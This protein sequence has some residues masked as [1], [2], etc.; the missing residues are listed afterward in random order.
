R[1]FVDQRGEELDE[2]LRIAVRGRRAL[3]DEP[4]AAVEIPADEEHARLRLDQGLAQRAEIAPRI[5]EHGRP[6]GAREPPDVA[7]R[8]EDQGRARRSLDSLLLSRAASLPRGGLQSRH[9]AYPTRQPPFGPTV[10]RIA[11]LRAIRG[12]PSRFSLRS[13]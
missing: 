7:M 6:L 12:G 5:D 1:P 4:G 3:T 13:M 9:R 11:R 2:S 8:R 10:A